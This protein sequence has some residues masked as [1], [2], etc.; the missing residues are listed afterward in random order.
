M[1]D[2]KGP[3]VIVL[4]SGGGGT[5]GKILAE[6][7]NEKGIQNRALNRYLGYQNDLKN[8]IGGDL[9]AN[10]VRFVAVFAGIPA[11]PRSKKDWEIHRK[12]CQELFSLCQVNKV[13][14]IYVS[15]LSAH[16]SN[17]SSY[18]T[19]KRLIE[20]DALKS[21]GR[22]ARFGIIQSSDPKSPYSMLRPLI[23][24]L[25]KFGLLNPDSKYYLTTEQNVNKF[26]TDISDYRST[27][28]PIITNYC[29]PVVY[30]HLGLVDMYNETM[31]V[32]SDSIN[33]SAT[34]E[35]SSSIRQKIPN[36]HKWL[37]IPF[38]FSLIDPYVNFYHGM[39]LFNDNDNDLRA[40]V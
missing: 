4:V 19:W 3:P 2:S 14:Y 34:R 33:L 30:N 32:T 21:G 22:I 11:Q 12:D 9:N 27:D 18:S 7:L 24:V 17:C 8:Y 38:T 6:K 16:E 13:P 26:A 20:Q 40:N 37:D 25:S 36:R 28:F 15:S 10:P 35:T 23:P 1:I 39:K 31:A 5:L 29:E